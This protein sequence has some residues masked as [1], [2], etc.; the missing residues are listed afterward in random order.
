M[1]C[2]PISASLASS[3]ADDFEERDHPE[4]ILLVRWVLCVPLFP[5]SLSFRPCFLFCHLQF[6]SFDP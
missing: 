1:R 4:V 6:P 5:L 3:Y 2:K